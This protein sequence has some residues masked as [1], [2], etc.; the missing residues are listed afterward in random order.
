MGPVEDLDCIPTAVS[1]NLVCE[2][3]PI[4]RVDV[5]VGHQPSDGFILWNT[6]EFRRAE[7]DRENRVVVK[8]ADNRRKRAEVEQLREYTFGIC[9][10]ARIRANVEYFWVLHDEFDSDLYGGR[11]RR[12]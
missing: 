7:V 2:S 4:P 1:S 10:R 6:E 12:G 11:P 3:K 9:G 8:A 5:V